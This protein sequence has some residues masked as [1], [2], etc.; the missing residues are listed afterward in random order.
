MI[1]VFPGILY[2]SCAILVYYYSIDHQT[3][4]TMQK[5]LEARRLAEAES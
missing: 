3:C 5:D 4:E 1:S 2:M